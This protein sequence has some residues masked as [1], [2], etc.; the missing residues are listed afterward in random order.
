MCNISLCPKSL[1]N[2]TLNCRSLRIVNPTQ[3]KNGTLCFATF[4][5]D[6]AKWSCVFD[7]GVIFTE[8]WTVF[9][10]GLSKF[11]IA[12]WWY[13]ISFAVE[14]T[15]FL[16]NVFKRAWPIH[17]YEHEENDNAQNKRK[18]RSLTSLG[19]GC[20]EQYISLQTY[21]AIQHLLPKI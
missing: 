10:K 3:N 12:F 11:P 9:S 4:N 15:L 7:W 19:E 1:V 20:I 18:R 8:I 13:Q 17:I 6:K 5:D 21:K 14:K 2:K 16:T